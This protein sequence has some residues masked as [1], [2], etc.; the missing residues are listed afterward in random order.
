[1]PAYFLKELP[2]EIAPILSLIF[3]SPLHQGVLP[4]DWKSANVIP[5]FKKGDHT[6]TCNY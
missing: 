1:M 6:K 3:Q 2:H 4:T 5:I